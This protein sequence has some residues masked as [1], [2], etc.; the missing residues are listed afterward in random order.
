M[1]HKI[2]VYRQN[3]I[4]SKRKRNDVLHMRY[5]PT[6]NTRQHVAIGFYANWNYFVEARVLSGWCTTKTRPMFNDSEF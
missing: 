3:L 2:R 5:L 4:Q 6:E 1:W